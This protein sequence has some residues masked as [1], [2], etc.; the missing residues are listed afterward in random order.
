MRRT[1]YTATEVEADALDLDMFRL[2]DRL[3]AFAGKLPEDKKRRLLDVA[4]SIAAARG[5]V[6]SLM[7]Y[8]RRRETAF[9]VEEPAP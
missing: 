4:S 3:A 9:G 8:E 7:H 2:S 5:V 6:R 1:S